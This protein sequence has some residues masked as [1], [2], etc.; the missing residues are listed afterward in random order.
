MNATV[1]R[2]QAKGSSAAMRSIV[3][4][5][6]LARLWQTLAADGGFLCKEPSKMQYATAAICAGM[7]ATN[8][9]WVNACPWGQLAT[10]Q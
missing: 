7:T 5:G 8:R 1:C 3:A 9:M 4:K 10:Y 2:V 6:C